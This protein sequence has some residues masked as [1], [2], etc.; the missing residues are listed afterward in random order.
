MTQA[1][2]SAMPIGLLEGCF[3]EREKALKGE[4]RMFHYERKEEFKQDL[5]SGP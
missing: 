2:S 1:C 4:I 5:L 3:M